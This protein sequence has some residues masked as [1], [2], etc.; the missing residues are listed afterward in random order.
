MKHGK[1]RVEM[2]L[3]RTKATGE[4]AGQMVDALFASWRPVLFRYALRLSGTRELAEDLVQEAFLALYRESVRGESVRDPRRWT[5]C[6]VRQQVSKHY[7]DRRR[8]GEVPQPP[9][10]LEAF[11]SEDTFPVRGSGHEEDV[12]RLLAILTP[13]EKEV[14]LLRLESLKYREIAAHLAVSPKTVA[15]L[16]ARALHKLQK[17]AHGAG[18]PE[19][20]FHPPAMRAP[21]GFVNPE[22]STLH[23][24]LG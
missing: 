17:A 20:G 15:A 22:L 13:R 18:D 19:N 6:V 9:E 12:G 14:I 24:A 23:A 1:R 7:R 8:H 2:K 10:V 21:A 5:L 16:L 11:V 3:T 4:E